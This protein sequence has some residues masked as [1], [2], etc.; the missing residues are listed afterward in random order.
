MEQIGI[1][2]IGKLGICFALNLERKGYSVIGVDVS[3]DYISSINKKTLLS[4]EPQVEDLLKKSSK[5]QATLD[6]K[7]IVK[8]EVETIFVFVATP[9]TETGEYNHQQVEKVTDDLIAYGKRDNVVQ[10]VIGCTTMPKYCDTLAKKMQLYNYEVSYNPEFI[11]QGNI[12]HNQQYPDQVLIGEANK[13]AGNII[14]AIYENM[15]EN[16]PVFCRMDRTS[17]EIAKIATNCFLTTKISFANSIGDL[18]ISAGADYEK[19]LNTIGADSRIGNKYLSYGFGFGGPCFPRDNRALNL[20]AK[21]E[22]YPLHI[23]EA[24][25]KVNK[26]HLEFQFKQYLLK[27]SDNDVIHFNGVTYKKG[28][29]LIEESQQLA[30]ALKLALYGRKVLIRDKKEVIDQILELYPNV[31]KTEITEY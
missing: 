18:A 30:L 31:F 6:I 8:D 4:H 14:Q 12:I 9:S 19:I 17:A 28:S 24:T 15:C 16:K 7:D 13:Q 5:L 22:K 23:S 29:V 26:E 25:D 27:Y 1:I 10:L 11:A 21:K 20:F 2:G 3:E